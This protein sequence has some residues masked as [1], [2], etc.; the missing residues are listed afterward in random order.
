MPS[1]S[2]RVL[3]FQIGIRYKEGGGGGG[4]GGPSFESQ[5]K[6]FTILKLKCIKKK[7]IVKA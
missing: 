2:V 3:L 4:G 5:W 1:F 7:V 6:Q